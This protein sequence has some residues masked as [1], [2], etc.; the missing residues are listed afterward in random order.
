M[1]FGTAEEIVRGCFNEGLSE[2]AAAE[3]LKQAAFKLASPEEKL[4]YERRF[5][6]AWMPPLVGML[7]FMAGNYGGNQTRHN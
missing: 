5:I 4:A 3:L 2:E 6:P 1:R 7:N